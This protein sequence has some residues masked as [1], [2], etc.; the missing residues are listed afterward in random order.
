MSGPAFVTGATGFV[1]G[2]VLR[3]LIADD[4]DVRALA[5]DRTGGDQLAAAGATPVIGHLFEPDVLREGMAGCETVFH[6]AGVNEMCTG[7]PGPMMRVNIDGV[8]EVMQAAAATGVR[9]VVFTSSA[10][11]LGEKKG[12]I[13]TEDS[14]HRGTYL[15]NYARS[16]HL[17]ELAAFEEGE[18]L[19]VEVV[20]VNP[21]SVQG[22]GRTR[23][24]A[25]LLIRA[26]GTRFPVLPATSLSIVDIDDCA[27]G[28]LLAEAQGAAGRRYLV[29]GATVTTREAIDLLREVT[30][31][32]I[33]PVVLP[34]AAVRVF[35]TP[36]AWLAGRTDD[37]VI[38][39]EMLRTL[40]HG[41]RYDGSRA[42]R[43]LGLEYTPLAETLR[44]T[45]Q[46]L[47]DFRFIRRDLPRIPPPG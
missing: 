15:S 27:R 29:S 40:L 41:H 14:L 35:G 26:L 2:A 5:R 3:H 32:S 47:V 1:G 39:P 31:A 24:S 43:E 17:G 7:D 46:W 25:Q 38:C 12:T 34:A 28:H 16:K 18:R 19:D 20:A 21:S 6:V 11:T 42:T 22:P 36:A 10:A 4:R 23:G 37:P 33:N 30:G 13:G 9:R 8:R 44:R 45:L